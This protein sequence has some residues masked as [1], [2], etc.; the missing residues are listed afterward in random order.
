MKY[1]SIFAI[2]A[3]A[4]VINAADRVLYSTTAPTA[5]G[6]TLPKTGQTSSWQDYDDGYYEKGNSTSPRFTDNGDGTVT[7]NATHLMWVK[8]VPNMC[9]GT[10]TT[11]NQ[12][13]SFSLLT[14]SGGYYVKGAAVR[15]MMDT[16]SDYVC[17]N[18]HTATADTVSADGGTNNWLLLD[19]SWFQFIGTLES[20]AVTYLNAL[21][22]CEDLVYAGYSDWRMPNILEVLSRKNFQDP[23]SVGGIY[24]A[25]TV[26]LDTDGVHTST[27]DAI[28]SPGTRN[29][30]VIFG[31]GA[32]G[33]VTYDISTDAFRVFPV[34]DAQ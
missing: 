5:T 1:L 11:N 31:S 20:K 2:F 14:E 18:A 15:D 32:A 17:I 22:L 23:Y 9:P 3:L 6:L 8:N 28:S 24:D 10:L 13:V 4:L 19:S 12:L 34:R 25:F 33:I 21:T 27:T 26:G 7:D 29:Y 16:A 30:A